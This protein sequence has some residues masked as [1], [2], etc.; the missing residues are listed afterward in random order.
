MEN[1]NASSCSYAKEMISVIYYCRFSVYGMMNKV[2][3]IAINLVSDFCNANGKVDT[4]LF[5]HSSVCNSNWQTSVE[6][7]LRPGT[8]ILLLLSSVISFEGPLI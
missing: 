2:C 1:A 7:R 5:S 3:V 8:T 4:Y 6:V